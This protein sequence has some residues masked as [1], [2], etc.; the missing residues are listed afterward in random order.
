M[1]VVRQA[2]LG[3][4]QVVGCAPARPGARLALPGF[5]GETAVSVIEW[6]EG[7]WRLH[8][9]CDGLCF[10]L[11]EQTLHPGAS[12]PVACGDILEAGL[13]RYVVE[14]A[15]AA[16]LTCAETGSS[17]P[18]WA[19]DGMLLPGADP[20]DIVPAPFDP[21]S[22]TGPER[23]APPDDGVNDPGSGVLAHLNRAYFRALYDPEAGSAPLVPQQRVQLAH[24]GDVVRDDAALTLEE[25]T[26]GVMDI[27][28]AIAR[29][30]SDAADAPSAERE[31][32]LWLFA[33][34]GALPP[35]R[36]ALPPLTRHDHHVMG[37]D[38]AQAFDRGTAIAQPDEQ[39]G[40]GA[41]GPGRKTGM[42][43]DAPTR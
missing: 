40:I 1:R 37:I 13:R 39:A 20:F 18:S 31:D 22:P 25:F 15:D 42:S 23:H 2:G 4:D 43:D 30:G 7:A 26:V 12:V 36:L 34:S 38:S 5:G 9:R 27:D 17:E 41:F 14:Q 6:D 28:M 29:L 16:D 10:Y 3:V 11:N 33:P 32:V 35:A 21:D 8:H 19:S 24:T